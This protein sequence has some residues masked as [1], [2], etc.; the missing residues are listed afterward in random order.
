MVDRHTALCR[1][2]TEHGGGR[3]VRKPQPGQIAGL[4]DGASG[5]ARP[6]PGALHS[7]R[8]QHTEQAHNLAPQPPA[9]QAHSRRRTGR[10]FHA[11]APVAQSVAA[12]PPGHGPLL[13]RLL[14]GER[15]HDFRQR[16]RQVPRP[17]GRHRR[18]YQVHKHRILHH[19]RRPH[20]HRPGPRPRGA[21]PSRGESAHH[22]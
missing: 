4:G 20:R 18:R 8:P 12:R 2:H 1:D 9:P 14:R 17:A 11:A 6:G 19:R 22:L 21:R 5:G 13:H 7:L 3:R 16:H 15:G 10:Q